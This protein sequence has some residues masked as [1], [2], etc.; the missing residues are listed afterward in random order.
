M[1]FDQHLCLFNIEAKTKEEILTTM[2]QMLLSHGIVKQDYLTGILEREQQYPT[3]LLVNSIG[4]AIPHTDS[5][6]VNQSQICF[7][8]LKH[9]VIF[10]G[11]TDDKEQIPV[12]FIFMLAMK[13]AH[14][15]VEN[16]QNLIGLFQNE[17][18]IKLLEQCQSTNEFI[19]ILNS[20][21]VK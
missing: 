11:M 16:L 18:Q 15:Q 14:E 13:Q 20:A 6:K 9:P 7:A 5:S 1:Y 21:G 3:G 19:S 2:A 4:F 12:K 8:S 17:E 10:S